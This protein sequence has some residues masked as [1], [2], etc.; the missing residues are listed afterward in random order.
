MKV[1]SRNAVGFRKIKLSANLL[2]RVSNVDNVKKMRILS[3]HFF[4]SD[5][6]D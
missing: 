2:S 3:R 1:S 6:V 5:S 4:V